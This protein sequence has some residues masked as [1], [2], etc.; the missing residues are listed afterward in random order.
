[1]MRHLL[2]AL[3]ILALALLIGLAAMPVMAQDS[4]WGGTGYAIKPTTGCLRMGS[5]DRRLESHAGSPGA[6]GAGRLRGRSAGSR[7]RTIT[8]ADKVTGAGAVVGVG[9]V[10]GAVAQADT[11]VTAAEGA[12][13]LIERP[14]TARHGSPEKL[15]PRNRPAW[16]RRRARC[17]T[18]PR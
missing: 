12:R 15:L 14:R 10:I 17:P 11:V 7:S 16:F 5:S 8:E 1:M 6:P 9:G 18:R 4:L 13:S 2:G 3:A